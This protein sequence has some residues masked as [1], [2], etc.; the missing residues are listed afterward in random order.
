MP[1]YWNRVVMYLQK[2]RGDQSPLSLF[3]PPGM[4]LGSTWQYNSRIH[5]ARLLCAQRASKPTS[6]I[7]FILH[8]HTPKKK[9]WL[10]LATSR[11][12]KGFLSK[13]FQHYPATLA[14]QLRLKIASFFNISYCQSGPCF[15]YHRLIMRELVAALASS[16]PMSRP[17]REPSA[18]ARR[19]LAAVLEGCSPN[20]AVMS[21]RARA[22]RRPP[23]QWR[24]TL[25]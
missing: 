10:T 8:T 9:P 3:V 13:C 7:Y 19:R 6:A 20:A 24:V 14:Q 21:R 17:R 22:G 25:C 18:N 16:A 4:N 1:L 12:W 15:I 11:R 23:P 5:L 2:I